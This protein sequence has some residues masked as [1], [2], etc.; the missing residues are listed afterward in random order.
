MFNHLIHI[1]IVI[2]SSKA[3]NLIQSEELGN[4]VTKHGKNLNSTALYHTTSIRESNEEYEDEDDDEGEE[5]YDEEYDESE[6]Y[7]PVV[8]NTNNVIVL[9]QDFDDDEDD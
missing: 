7:I 8:D 4:N 9:D 5:E 1:T 2:R 6:I 3:D